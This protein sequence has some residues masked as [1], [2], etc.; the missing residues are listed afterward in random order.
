MELVVQKMQFP[1]G[2]GWTRAGVGLRG[3]E[4]EVGEVGTFRMRLC[5]QTL[6]PIQHFRVQ[7]TEDI[8]GK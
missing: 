8:Q 7:A 1:V 4:V 2:W 3:A 5:P 6:Q